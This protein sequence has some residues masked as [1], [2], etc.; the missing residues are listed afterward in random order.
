MYILEDFYMDALLTGGDSSQDVI[1]VIR[2]IQD[3]LKNAKFSLRKWISNNS[4]VLQSIDR[5]VR[6]YDNVGDI[7]SDESLGL[8]WHHGSDE[9]DYKINDNV[10]RL[11]VTKRT[12][13]AVISSLYDPIDFLALTIIVAKIFLQNLWISKVNC[14]LDRIVFYK[15]LGITWLQ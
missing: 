10:K 4:D 8:H 14:S 12:I 3:V 7:P 6:A 15:K 13:L 11:A 5:K 9:F 2:D 1:F